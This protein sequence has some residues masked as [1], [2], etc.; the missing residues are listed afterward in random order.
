MAR[1]KL[2]ARRSPRAQ[3]TENGVS[4]FGFAFAFAGLVALTACSTAFQTSPGNESGNFHCSKDRKIPPIS[5]T[6]GLSDTGPHHDLQVHFGQAFA[7][8][9][10][11]A[12][13]DLTEPGATNPDVVCQAT[14]TPT[15]PQRT[16]TFVATDLGETVFVSGLIHHGAAW[17]EYSSGRVTVTAPASP[18]AHP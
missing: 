9:L 3:R 12:D 13:G 17:V 6:I 1:G 15:G 2:K 14:K 7:V 5:A 16:I 11:S 10:T 4:I 18:E 8:S